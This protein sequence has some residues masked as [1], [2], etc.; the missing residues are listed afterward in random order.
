[1]EIG[2]EAAVIPESST[3]FRIL[4]FSSLMAAQPPQHERFLAAL[5]TQC[6]IDHMHELVSMAAYTDV[7]ISASVLVLGNV[8]HAISTIASLRACFPYVM[9]R[10]E[11]HRLI[12]TNTTVLSG[13]REVSTRK[14]ASEIVLTA[15]MAP[16]GSLNCEFLASKPASSNYA[17][18][19]FPYP[20]NLLR[21]VARTYARAK[22]TLMLDVDMIPSAELQD[23]LRDALS[24]VSHPE[25]TAI[26]VPG[27][28]LCPY[29]HIEFS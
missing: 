20:N 15:E 5:A 26:V 11:F 21:N 12:P 22:Y 7:P 25:N 14:K 19:N 18:E 9:D 3:T 10:V 2:L 28:P 17:L 4:H 1:M 6:S 24:Q 13:L 16:V 8:A 27:C 29:C 23:V